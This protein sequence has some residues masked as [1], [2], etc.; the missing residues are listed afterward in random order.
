MNPKLTL[1]AAA[2]VLVGAGVAQAAEVRQSVEIDRPPAQVWEAVGPWCGLPDWHPVFA[3]CEASQKD[4]KSYRTLTTKDGAKL[5][6]ELRSRD[7]AGRRFSYAI[8]ESPLPLQGY[9]SSVWVEPA[10]KGS[11]VVWEST[12]EPKGTSAE[13][14]TKLVTGV[15]RAG[16]DNL[17]IKLER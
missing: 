15:Y 13:E 12:F 7:D 11:R 4:G 14:A 6:E 16:L 9:V 17:K 1:G 3:S 10:G 5:F 8:V 2:A